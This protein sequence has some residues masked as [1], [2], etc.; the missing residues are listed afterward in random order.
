MFFRTTQG[1]FQ[2]MKIKH[3]MAAFFAVILLFNITGCQKALEGGQPQADVLSNGGIAAQQGDWI[4]Y[5]NGGIPAMLS[6]AK[7]NTPQGTLWRMKADGT[8]KARIS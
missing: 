3:L 5:I 8:E 1:G 6:Q 2:F 7:S 4:Y